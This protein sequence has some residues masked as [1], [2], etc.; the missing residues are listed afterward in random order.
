MTCAAWFKQEQKSSIDSLYNSFGQR[1]K[2]VKEFKDQMLG[3]K[4][5]EFILYDTSKDGMEAY[6]QLKGPDSIP[7][8]NVTTQ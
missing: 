4:K 5:H 7:E 8:F 1:F 2:S 3:L 6:C